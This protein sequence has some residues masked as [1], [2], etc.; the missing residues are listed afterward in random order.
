MATMKAAMT[1]KKA[2]S[3]TIWFWPCSISYLS[4]DVIQHRLAFFKGVLDDTTAIP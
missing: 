4:F 2:I 3:G 1:T